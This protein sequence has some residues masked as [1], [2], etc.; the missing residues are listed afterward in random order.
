MKK[1]TRQIVARIFYMAFIVLFG[2]L[3]VN[4][5][6][7]IYESRPQLEDHSWQGYINWGDNLAYYGDYELAVKAVET[8]ISK[9]PQ[10]AEGYAFLADVYL[11]ATDIEN[12]KKVYADAEEKLG[13]NKLFD[14]GV[15]NIANIELAAID[16]NKSVVVNETSEDTPKYD[17]TRRYN[18]NGDIVYSFARSRDWKKPD[19]EMFYEYNSSNQ[20]LKVTELNSY[21]L[22]SYTTYQYHD[23]GNI[24]V[25]TICDFDGFILSKKIYDEQYVKNVEETHAEDKSY[26]VEY[27]ADGEYVLKKEFYNTS[28]ELEYYAEYEMTEAEEYDEVTRYFD[29][30]NN[31]MVTVLHKYI[32]T[33]K[34]V[35][36]ET[37][38]DAEGSVLYIVDYAKDKNY[39]LYSG[40][41]EE[42]VKGNE[43]MSSKFYADVEAEV[44]KL[45]NIKK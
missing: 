37:Y 1:R 22:P 36:R 7:Y 34:S 9:E 11:R 2:Y 41:T 33:V 29:S 43:I 15:S 23:N 3:M 26:Y 31:P 28:E 6:G 39:Y 10:K 5:G 25:E 4:L 13:Q 17:T 27:F 20:L 14:E 16:E 35:K 8:A 40:D 19:I 45:L 18:E 30:E 32:S 44:H 24:A 12:A 21:A 38:L 42:L